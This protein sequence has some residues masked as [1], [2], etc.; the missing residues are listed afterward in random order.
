MKAHAIDVHSH[1]PPEPHLE[2]IEH[3]GASFGESVDR[4]N[5]KGPVRL[6]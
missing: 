1:F 4:S 2:L 3:E 5:P 6:R